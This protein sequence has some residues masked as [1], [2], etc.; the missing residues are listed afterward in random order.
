MPKVLG[1]IPARMRSGRFPGKPMAKIRGIPMIG[2]C[3]LRSRQ[4]R[5]LDELRVATCDREV[6]D[7]V[8]SIGGKAQMTKASHEMCTDRV[9]EATQ[10]IESELGE[11]FDIVVNIQGDQP[12][13]FPEMIDEVVQALIDDQGT[14]CSTMME[15]TSSF[16][17]HDDPNR[18]KIVVDKQGYAMYMSRE[19]IPSRKKWSP[20]TELP[21]YIHVALIAFRRDFLME[22]GSYGMTPLESIESVDYLRA[23]ENGHRIKMVLTGIPTKTV[24]TSE[25]LARVEIAMQ[26]DRLLP[27]YL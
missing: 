2:H 12:M 19:P 24:D 18:I 4:S 21:I 17:D 10:H 26:D 20:K 5:L 23:M 1:I 16:E 13:V 15:R 14:L 25:D 8:Q 3:Y 27:S 22:F 6:F 11:R 7:Y 9:V